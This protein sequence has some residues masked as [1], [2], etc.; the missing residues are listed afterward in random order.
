MDDWVMRLAEADWCGL[1]VHSRN[2]IVEYQNGSWCLVR[3]HSESFGLN[4]R[5]DDERVLEWQLSSILCE[6]N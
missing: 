3:D 5:D 1:C 2:Q 4:D 6:L